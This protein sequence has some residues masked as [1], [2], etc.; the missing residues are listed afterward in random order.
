MP[1]TAYCKA[2]L[3]RSFESLGQNQHRK[4]IE[5]LKEQHN[6]NSTQSIQSMF[7][8]KSCKK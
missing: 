4:E 3:Q 6:P 2:E 1:F 7:H 5:D 8:V